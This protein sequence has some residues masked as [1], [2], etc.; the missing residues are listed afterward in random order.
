MS[1]SPE[2][3][4]T[5]DHALDFP[6]REAWRAWLAKHHATHAE[7]WV[8]HYKKGSPREGLR[9]AEGVEE[10]LCFGW[11][12][13]KMTSLD[14]DRM[15]Q[16]YSPRKPDSVWARSNIERVERLTAQGKMTPAGLAMVEEAQRRGTWQAAVTE[17][18]RLPL[19]DDLEQ[20][21][22]AEPA[23][24]RAFSAFARSYWNQY[25]YWVQAAK[26]TPTRTK[27]IAEVVERAKAGKKP[28]EP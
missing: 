4:A 18:D 20:A 6:H 2:P 23:A 25:I 22:R 13:S 15:A 27:R 11:I 8:I 19:P 21:L 3:G 12:D 14:A 16:R 24:W 28:G 7:V 10:A 5:R 9:Y 1:S 26:R 17:S